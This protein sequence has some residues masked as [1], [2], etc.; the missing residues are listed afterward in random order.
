M[1]KKEFYAVP[2]CDTAFYDTLKNICGLWVRSTR[3]KHD[4][5]YDIMEFVAEFNDKRSPVRFNRGTDAI[6]LEGIHFHV[7]CLDGTMH[8]WN[9]YTFDASGISSLVLAENTEKR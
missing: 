5:G 9:N 1:K 3:K 4:S 6:Y 2:A 8:I 7:D